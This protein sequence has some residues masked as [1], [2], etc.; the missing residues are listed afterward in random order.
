MGRQIL[1]TISILISKRPDTVRKCLD[2]VKPLLDSIPSE[3]ILTDT[4]CGAEVRSIIEEYTDQI[5]PFEWCG[6]FAKA[7]NT[8]LKQAR[9]EWFLFLDDDE[10]FEDV[11]ELIEFFQSGEHEKYGMGAY[12]QRN[13]LDQSGSVYS[14]L[15]VGRMIRLL[16]DVQF[17]YAI[18]ECF[19]RVP[20]KIKKFHSYV[21][22]YGYAYRSP[23]EALEHA[24]RNISLLL[25]E[26]RAAPE[27]MKHTLQLVQE[28]NAIGEYHK[29]LEISAEGI[30][31]AEKQQIEHGFCVPSLYA[32]EV[33]CYLRL[34]RYED[35]RAKGEQY[36]KL[37][38][39]DA[40]AK[41]MIAGS[42][43]VVYMAQG[44]SEKCLEQVQSFADTCQAYEQNEESFM[45]YIT[46]I[47]CD[48]FGQRNLGRVLG[49]G[50][51][52]AV[53]TGR[54]ETAYRWFMKLE[55]QSKKLFVSNEMIK[56]IVSHVPETDE[57]DRQTYI[58]M[59]NTMLE[60]KELEELIVR[61]IADRISA[62]TALT[63]KYKIMSC[64]QDIQSE[65]RFFRLLSI[66]SCGNAADMAAMVHE[67]PLYQ[68]KQG[69][70]QY[71]QNC[72]AEDMQ[73]WE[74]CLA[75]C[76]PEDDLYW[77]IWKAVSALETAVRATCTVSCTGEGAANED[78]GADINS[79]KE[80]DRNLREFV[81]YGKQICERLYLP[82]VIQGRRDI[83]SPEMQAAYEIGALQEQMTEKQYGEAVHTVKCIK[84]LFP[85]LDQGMK[86]Y[87]QWLQIQLE[88]Q[89]T[90][91]EQA[92]SEL[93]RLGIQVKQ[94]VREFMQMGEYDS[95][96]AVLMQIALLLP[97]DEEIRQLENELMRNTE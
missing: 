81:R 83:L 47:T 33:E 27:N 40:L 11:T 73:W 63:D 55:W 19:N 60:R 91:A 54:T 51:R 23:K 46:S 24:W 59:C 77:Q 82:E 80:I 64:Y 25:R 17:M 4:G 61:T 76:L 57:R 79:L 93:Q 35:A 53:Q 8:G 37:Q 43:S 94:K 88:E 89:Q 9:G 70:K 28:F 87:L 34:Y 52:A 22:H 29:S 95:A 3:L 13:Y 1:L 10:W 30:A 18:H 75:G 85:R 58:Q 62:Q 86:Q 84:E 6:D 12:I 41:A 67:I 68:W 65:H 38:Q 21:H 69:L 14:D 45:G 50:I 15:V 71:I 49:N 90:A 2:S 78:L 56:A 44:E 72:T 97:E 32:N 31:A 74:E 16:P 42:L 20:G 96:R 92:A 36:L 39:I 26:H 48:C 7:R 5:I 66:I